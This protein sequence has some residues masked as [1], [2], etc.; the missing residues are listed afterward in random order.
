MTRTYPI[1]WAVFK[2]EMMVKSL[3]SE[4]R[5]VDSKACQHET[6]WKYQTDH[7]GENPRHS[8][9]GLLSKYLCHV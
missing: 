8:S 3:V 5:L 9:V 2:F 1:S 7:Q 6:V 4:M